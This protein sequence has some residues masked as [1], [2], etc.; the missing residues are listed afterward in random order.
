VGFGPLLTGYVLAVILRLAQGSATVAMITS[1]GLTAPL[2]IAAPLTAPQLG[3]LTIAIAAG[4]S[5]GSHVNDSGFWLVGRIFGITPGE[6]LRTWTVSTT[7]ISVVGFAMCS[8][9]YLLLAVF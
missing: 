9:I 5:T 2:L 4:A 3:L 6:T 8:L 7:L 1:A